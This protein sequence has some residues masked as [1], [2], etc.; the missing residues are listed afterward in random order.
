MSSGL[1]VSSGELVG[2][3][4]AADD[5]IAGRLSG[6]VRDFVSHSGIPMSLL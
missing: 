4:G 2:W 3:L 1:C 5:Y 6:Q